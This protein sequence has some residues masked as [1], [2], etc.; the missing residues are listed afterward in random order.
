[1]TATVWPARLSATESTEEMY[2]PSASSETSPRHDPQLLVDEQELKRAIDYLTEAGATEMGP[3]NWAV[4]LRLTLAWLTGLTYAEAAR[5]VGI[6]PDNLTRILHGELRLQPST[7]D[8]IKRVLNMTLALRALLHD[9]DLATWFR[10]PVPV[11]KGDT[12]LEALRKGKL[13]RLER[14]VSSY[15]DEQY[16]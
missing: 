10:T 16:A 4:A 2:G 9:D 5:V 6:A 15:F 12:P 8:R 7:H 3:R 14:V 11:L 13:D 1:M